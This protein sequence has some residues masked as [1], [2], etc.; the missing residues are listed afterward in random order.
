MANSVLAFSALG[1]A[2]WSHCHEASLEV[3]VTSGI[4]LEFLEAISQYTIPTLC[5]S[6]HVGFYK[7][8]GPQRACVQLLY[9]QRDV[10]NVFLTSS[11][12]FREEVGILQW[13]RHLYHC[14]KARPEDTVYF[15]FSQNLSSGELICIGLIWLFLPQIWQKMTGIVWLFHFTDEESQSLLPLT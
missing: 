1:R 3:Q 7:Q 4:Y 2:V 8:K 12:N 5:A 14:L 9:L 6:E 15:D 13:G 11:G 10:I